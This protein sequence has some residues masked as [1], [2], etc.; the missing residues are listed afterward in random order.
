M[1]EFKTYDK[2]INNPINGNRGC[3]T[4]NM[5]LINLNTHQ[6]WSYT[7]L[8]SN[9]KMIKCKWVFKMKYNPDSFI[10]RYKRKFVA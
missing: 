9:Q 6:I 3:E 10:K 4:V 5:E 7:P 1:Q 2:A 8:L